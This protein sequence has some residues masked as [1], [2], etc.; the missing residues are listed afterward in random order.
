MTPKKS[1]MILACLAAGWGPVLWPARLGA[2]SKVVPNW[3]IDPAKELNPDCQWL[4]EARWGVFAHYLAHPASTRVPIEMSAQQWNQKVDSFRIK[5]LA[6]QLTALRAPYFFITI[7]QGGGYYCS[8]NQTYE[9]L[10][11]PSGGKLTTRDLVAELAKELPARGIRLGVYLPAVGRRESAEVQQKW[12]EVITEWSERWGEAISA[13]W[14][15][16]AVYQSPDTFKAFT[17]AFRT[18]SPRALVSYNVGP[19]GMEPDPK[20]P[21]TVHE[22]FLA[23]ETNWHLPVSGVRPWDG[24]KYYM[25]PNISGDQLHFLTFLGSFWGR[26][27]PRFPDDL[28]VGWTKHTNNHG[29]TI[30]W[31][32]PLSDEGLIPETHFRQLKVLSDKVGGRE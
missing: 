10:F 21:V 32:V 24:K 28:V 25:G 20:L 19:L 2:Q 29:G 9:R 17:A 3:Q 31:D 6:D 12:R 26:G 5:A 30:S 8:P 11:G 13:W 18:G 27:E 23:G 22:D 4:R 1:L 16:G 14:I 15:D 7:G